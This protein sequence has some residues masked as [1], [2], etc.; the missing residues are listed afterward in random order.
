MILRH[1]PGESQPAQMAII[2]SSKVGGAVVRNKIKR[3]LL[4]ILRNNI[5]Q[6]LKTGYFLIIA[7][8]SIIHARF[9]QLAGEILELTESISGNSQ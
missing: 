4:A 7:K 8:K 3:Q 1:A 9:N 6:S 2:V 5:G